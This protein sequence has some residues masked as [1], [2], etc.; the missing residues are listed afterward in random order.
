MPYFT[1]KGHSIYYREKGTGPLLVFLPGNTASSAAHVPDLERYS[2]RFRTVSLDFLGTGLSERIDPWPVTWWKECAD[3]TAGLI[4]HLGEKEAILV[5]IS[6]G[7]IVALLAA[8][9][10]PAKVAAAAADSCAEYFAVETVD[11]IIVEDRARRGDDQVMFWHAMHG[12]DWER[13]VDAD[14]GMIRT[15]AAEIGDC[16]GG[17]LPEISARVL[18]T[19]SLLGDHIPDFGGQMESMRR[20]IPDCTLFLAESGGHPLIWT[21]PK[22][23]HDTLEEFLE[24]SPGGDRESTEDC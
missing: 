17:R 16:F 20:Q 4:S 24:D 7:G 3:Q 18:L 12:D 6:G 8:V 21:E 5:G 11:R 22:L 19:G 1:Y 15:F 9:H 10:Y 14:T 23:F 13:V 2:D